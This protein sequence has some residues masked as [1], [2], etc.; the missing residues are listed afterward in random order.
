[1]LRKIE[2]R[3]RR[4]WQRMIQL[5]DITNSMDTSLSQLRE[6]VEDREAW[7]PAVHGLAK[8]QTWLSD[9]TELRKIAL[10]VTSWW[11]GSCW[12]CFSAIECSP[13][14][15]T[16]EIQS[17]GLLTR[18]LDAKD[19]WN[20]L[21]LIEMGKSPR[22][23]RYFPRRKRMPLINTITDCNCIINTNIDY[24]QILLSDSC[25][26]VSLVARSALLPSASYYQ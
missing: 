21:K 10:M 22:A 18:R 19:W 5:D 20:D 24:C 14:E 11:P 2:G 4:E 13:M 25:P 3:M 16:M 23:R 12:F 26:L 15:G 17:W 7:C 1:M 6:I 8:S 9:W